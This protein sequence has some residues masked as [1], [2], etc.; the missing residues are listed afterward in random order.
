M[1][2]GLFLQFLLDVFQRRDLGFGFFQAEA[3]GVV[4]VEFFDGDAAGVSF[5]EVFVV[6]E[7]AVVSGDAVEVAH[8]L[9]L[10]A[11]FL[12]QEGLVHLLA[13]ADADDLD[14]LLLSA[15][16]LADG[17]GLGLDGA[18]GGFLDEDVAVLSM[19]EGEQD[20]VDGFVQRHDEPG[21]GRFGQGHRLPGA[22]LVDPQ[23]DD[24]AAG[25]HHVAVAG[26][27]DLRAQGVPALSDRDLL[28][29]GLADAHRIDRVRRLVRR[30]ADHAFHT[31]VDGR[32][33]HVVRADDIGLHGLHREELAAG[34]LL[35][36]RRMEDVIDPAHRALQGRFVPHVADIELD[37]VRHV[38]VLRLILV[39]HVVLFLL[40]PAED[41]DL[42]D[43]GPEEP[44]QHRIS[45]TPGPP[46]NHQCLV[47]ENGHIVDSF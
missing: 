35:Q 32:V 30:Q 17:F 11:L 47:F 7:V 28:F 34:D 8:V 40:I 31:L 9:G 10:G 22:D 15:E 2:I 6:V 13:V 45:E 43:V 21:H 29:Q 1:N 42:A 16:E 3:A 25:A 23:G 44:P 12:G 37:L 20:Q 41:P 18:G 26:A 14:V 36:R 46:G 5:H 19:L 39:P 38:R 24:A 33:Q 27:A 4:G